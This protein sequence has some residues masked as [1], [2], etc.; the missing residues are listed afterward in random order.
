MTVRERRLPVV[1]GAYPDLRRP[2]VGC[3][4]QA[5]CPFVAEICRH[6]PVPRAAA[7]PARHAACVRIGDIPASGL[8]AETPA[9]PPV[10][11]QEKRVLAADGLR[12]WHRVV[13]SLEFL[14]PWRK[15]RRYIKAVD[16]VSLALRPGE[17]LGL[18]G[19]SGCGKSTIARALLGLNAAEGTITLQGR[20]FSTPRHLD[21]DYR[22]RVQIIF[23][24]PDSSL[25]PRKRVRD[26]IGRPLRL[27][28]LARRTELPAMVRE[29]LHSV[30]LPESYADR[31]PHE[32]SGGEK[33]RVA[34]ARALACRPDV[35]ICDELTSGLDVST[36]ATIIN[37]LADLQDH[38][39]LAYLFIA[40][41]LN[42]VHYVS[43]RVAVM[44]LGRIVETGEGRR[45]FDPPFHPYTEALISAAMVADP[46]MAARRVRLAGT[47]P[48]LL[49]P[50]AGCRF[51][52]R[53]HRRIG[54]ICEQ[55]DP[56]L[57]DRGQAHAIACH[58]PTPD[59]ARIPPIWQGV[60]AEKEERN[61]DAD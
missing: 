13:H 20:A 3:I 46:G 50:P 54:D 11:R 51:H 49:D 6:G 59:L 26:L 24:H 2:P 7:G 17:T 47:L 48:S 42:L 35:V 18:V 39:G 19:E 5:R 9:A 45:I 30:R 29:I 21:S 23:Q 15:Q 40:H 36:Q 41:D 53:C 34:I 4:F 56:S 1:T 33:Q 44:Y 27:F 28:R 38:T 32:L 16:D 58:I 37:L 12:V 61:A 14:T 60:P 31:Y 22:R 10:L 55:Q 52:T 8:P 57:T 43:D 25:N